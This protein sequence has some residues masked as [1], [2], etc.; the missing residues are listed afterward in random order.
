DRLRA[1]PDWTHRFDLLAGGIEV[2]AL[3]ARIAVEVG[4]RLAVLPLGDQRHRARVGRPRLE[5]GEAR[6]GI[7]EPVAALRVLALVDKVEANLALP[8][9]RVGQAAAIDGR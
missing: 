1:D 2:R 4:E 6:L 5:A 8:A 7:R 9:D 3:V